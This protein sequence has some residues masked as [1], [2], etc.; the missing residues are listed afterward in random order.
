MTQLFVAVLSHLT[1]VTDICCS[2]ITLQPALPTTGMSGSSY[3][4]NLSQVITQPGVSLTQGIETREKDNTHLSGCSCQSLPLPACS[5]PY[6]SHM[7]DMRLFKTPCLRY[8]TVVEALH[9]RRAFRVCVCSV[10]GVQVMSES[11][12][13]FART[14]CPNISLAA[15]QAL[16]LIGQCPMSTL[17]CM[18]CQCI[19]QEPCARALTTAEVPYCLRDKWQSS[20]SIESFRTLTQQHGHWTVFRTMLIT[21]TAWHRCGRKQLTISVFI[22]RKFR[23]DLVFIVQDTK[24]TNKSL[25]LTQNSKNIDNRNCNTWQEASLSCSHLSI[26]AGNRLSNR[27]VMALQSKRSNSTTELRRSGSG[28]TVHC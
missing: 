23:T 19:E 16:I 11:P 25:D 26:P 13:N 28:G 14:N 10:E 22:V 27:L 17:Y 20:P 5:K 18:P 24:Q 9:T 21:R 12:V 7:H 1:P 4:P 3:M 8:I 6:L 2:T 15:E